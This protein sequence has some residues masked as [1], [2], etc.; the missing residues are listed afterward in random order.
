MPAGMC[1]FKGIKK[2]KKERKDLRWICKENHSANTINGH[3]FTSHL[4]C[5]S[6][7]GGMS[8]L[9]ENIYS[10]WYLGFFQLHVPT[11]LTK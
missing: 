5:I 1:S 10:D 9:M 7:E 11:F 6:R 4:V 2:K 8:V 3:T